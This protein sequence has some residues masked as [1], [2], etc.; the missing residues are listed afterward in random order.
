MKLQFDSKLEFEFKM[1][2]LIWFPT[3]NLNGSSSPLLLGRHLKLAAVFT[4]YWQLWLG[5]NNFLLL[6][7]KSLNSAALIHS[8]SEI[9]RQKGAKSAS[10][11]KFLVRLAK[12][13]RFYLSIAAR[14]SMGAHEFD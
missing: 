12:L 2:I 4:N 5:P 8:S 9:G 13:I 3:S 11:G 14:S 10:F 1:R 6:R 7:L